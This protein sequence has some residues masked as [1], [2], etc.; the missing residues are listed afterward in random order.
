M[1]FIYRLGPEK[2]KAWQKLADECSHVIQHTDHAH[3]RTSEESPA[4]L[5]KY[6]GDYDFMMTCLVRVL[7][8]DDV[9]NLIASY[10][11]DCDTLDKC[12]CHDVSCAN[13]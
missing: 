4:T 13:E 10:V 3:R 11:A 9:A 6:Q 5:L 12:D 1:A 7:D 2:L 8:Q